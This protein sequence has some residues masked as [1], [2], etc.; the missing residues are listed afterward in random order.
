MTAQSL[1]DRVAKRLKAAGQPKRRSY[2]NLKPFRS[3]YRAPD[4]ETGRPSLYRPEYCKRA[5]EFMGMGVQCHCPGR[6]TGRCE[7]HDIRV[8]KR[9]RGVFRRYK[10]RHALP[11]LQRSKP[12]CSP[13]RKVLA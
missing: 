2:A 1:K 8:D 13:H 6:G 10:K 11:V 4:Y 5:I 12:S 9:S 3:S 7:G